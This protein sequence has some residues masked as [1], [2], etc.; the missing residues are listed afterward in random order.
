MRSRSGWCFIWPPPHLSPKSSSDIS[1]SP[2]TGCSGAAF[3]IRPPDM[4]ASE[5]LLVSVTG[6]T[7]VC[8]PCSDPAR[9]QV[10][11][12]IWSQ[13]CGT[14]IIQVVHALLRRSAGAQLF[15]RKQ[16]V[17]LLARANKI[18]ASLLI[19][20]TCQHAF[21]PVSMPRSRLA[22]AAAGRIAHKQ[23]S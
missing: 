19:E 5:R 16:E 8:P 7:C 17:E 1:P 3:Y 20:K 9:S 15:Q 23:T 14:L 21:S 22:R 10:P 6:P 4:C 18:H 2:S 13:S 11:C 12:R